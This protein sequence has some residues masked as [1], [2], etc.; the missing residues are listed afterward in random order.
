MIVLAP[1]YRQSL[2]ACD[3]TCCKLLPHTPCE[4]VSQR[5][6]G[7]GLYGFLMHDACHCTAIA[8][9]A[10]VITVALVHVVIGAAFK[11]M[12]VRVTTQHLRTASI[13]TWLNYTS[14][15][16]AKWEKNHHWLSQ[17]LCQ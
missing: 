15:K 12:A 4:T 5:G 10:V 11:T 16:A 7:L 1:S 17:R 2:P 13:P 3:T 8:V 9:G 6:P 14:L